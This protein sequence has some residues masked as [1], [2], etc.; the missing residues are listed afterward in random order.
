MRA[1]KRAY[2]A[3]MILFGVGLNS[4][5]AGMIDKAG[6]APWEICG[7]CHGLDGNSHMAKF[8]KLAGQK[9]AYI[10]K[11]FFDFRNLKRRN[12]GGQMEAITHEV[13]IQD[14]ESIALYFAGQS[15]PTP[16]PI[17]NINT[18]QF[19]QGRELYELG[20]KNI[21]ACISCHNDSR[22]DTPW[23]HAQHNAYLIKQLHDFQQDQREND[24]DSTM[25]KV[26]KSLTD[27]DIDALAL[28]LSQTGLRARPTGS[29]TK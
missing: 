9:S 4:A 26:A 16:T 13:E 20:R 28:Y 17:T 8:P 27:T 24:L 2:P 19:Q 12:D 22:K 25:R 21:P 15:A 10:E 23:L 18:E 5:S 3:L 14:I 1:T 11:Q 6:M 7:L 29:A